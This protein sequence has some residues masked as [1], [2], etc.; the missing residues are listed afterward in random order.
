MLICK[1]LVS[2]KEFVFI[3]INFGLACRHDE[4]SVQSRVRIS[5]RVN[6]FN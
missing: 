1:D 3:I 2:E 6:V 4:A 5:E